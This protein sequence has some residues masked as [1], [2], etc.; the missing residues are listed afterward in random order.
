MTIL[1]GELLAALD[2]SATRAHEIGYEEA[3]EELGLSAEDVRR[4]ATSWGLDSLKSIPVVGA[5]WHDVVTALGGAHMLG[6]VVG[7]RLGK[8]YGGEVPDS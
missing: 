1:G 4:V 7:M 8:L 6:I 3:I 5:S 2:A